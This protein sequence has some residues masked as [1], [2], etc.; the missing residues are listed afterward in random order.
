MI[1]KNTKKK[2]NWNNKRMKDLK[3]GK[4]LQKLQQLQ[5][6]IEKRNCALAVWYLLVLFI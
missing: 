1:K 2:Q 5:Q 4:Y 3:K 6:R